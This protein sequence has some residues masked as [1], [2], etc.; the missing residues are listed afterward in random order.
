MNILELLKSK[1]STIYV[2][3]LN[4]E[5][6]KAIFAIIN[7]GRCGDRFDINKMDYQKFIV[8]ADADVDGLHIYT[9]V[10]GGIM[11]FAP[12]II[13]SGRFYRAQPPLFG[14]NNG[15]EKNPK[16]KYYNTEQE[17]LKYVQGLFIKDNT[18]TTV[19][20]STINAKELDYITNLNIDYTYYVNN[21]AKNAIPI[22]KQ[23]TTNFFISISFLN[24]SCSSI[25]CYNCF[26]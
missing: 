22:N 10:L 25:T 13:E 12:Q 14:I 11:L 8:N 24:L 6:V 4:N 7:N 18:I 26:I 5:E 2:K 20:N 9:L 15:T 23:I 21:I 3:Y 19:K 17:Y 1:I 16:Y